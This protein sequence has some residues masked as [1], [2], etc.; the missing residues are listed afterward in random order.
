MRDGAGATTVGSISMSTLDAILVVLLA[1]L[2]VGS[3]FLALA[4]VAL[5]RVQRVTFA[6]EADPADA[7]AGRVLRL[8][9]EL[10]VVLNT[11]LLVVLFAQVCAAAISGYLAQRWFGGIGVTVVAMVVTI[12]LFIYAEVIPKTMALRAPQRSARRVARPIRVLVTVLR[13]V[14]RGLLAI[15]DAH[16]P[17]GESSVRTHFTEQELRSLMVES[18]QA[19]AIEEEDAV[20]VERSFDF[21]DVRV[22]EVRVPRDRI[23]AADLSM[24]VAEA[25]ALALEHGHRRL[26]VT[27]GGIDAIVGVVRLRDLA[28]ATASSGARPEVGEL[29]SAPLV[30]S[31]VESVAEVLRRMQATGRRF[32]VVAERGGPTE[33]IVTIEDLVAELVGEIEEDD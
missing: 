11:V 12:V 21:G 23:V 20:L 18:A 24:D 26:P 13:P 16:M 27:D 29:A 9:D 33:G 1:I 19:G 5:L 30:V 6:A 2:L 15:A 32:A 3:A 4:E 25:L 17:G 8:L 31:P 7:S 14:T 22:G 28:A 10:P